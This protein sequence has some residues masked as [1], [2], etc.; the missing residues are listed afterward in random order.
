MAPLG[1][2]ETIGRAPCPL[3]GIFMFIFMGHLFFLLKISCAFLEAE[4]WGSRVEKLFQ[5]LTCRSAQWPEFKH[6]LSM[7]VPGCSHQH[8]P[9]RALPVLVK[10]RQC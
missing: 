1:V 2:S 5:H 4:E 8:V 10:G 6:W 7:P 3:F 9:A